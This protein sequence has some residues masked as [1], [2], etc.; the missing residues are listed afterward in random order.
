MTDHA[1][2]AY[3]EVNYPGHPRPS[4]HPD[5]LATIASL[6]GMRPP[7]VP[8]CRVL[9]LG[10]GA[11]QNLVPMAYGLPGSEFLGVDLSR[12]HIDRGTR[13]VDD[14]GLKNVRLLHRN[15]MDVTVELG[16]FDYIIVH[17]VYS[18]VPSDV[19]AK[20]LSILRHQLS[21]NGVAFI[22]YNAYPGSHFRNLARDLMSFHTYRVVDPKE[23]SEQSRKVL[24]VLAELM[25]RDDVYGAVIRDQ[26]D[27][28]RKTPDAVLYH[29]DLAPDAVSFLLH[30]VVDDAARY[31]LQY[32]SEASLSQSSLGAIPPA[33]A[34]FLSQIP[35]NEVVAR[36]QYFDFLASRAFHE[37]LFCRSDVRLRR[38]VGPRCIQNYYLVGRF[39]PVSG[40][41]DPVGCE[42]AAFKSGRGGTLSTDHRLTQV[43]L[44]TLEDCW[45]SAVSFPDLLERTLLR[46]GAQAEGIKA[47]LDE[48]V[49]ALMTTLFRAYCAD[50]IEL[51]LYPPKLATT[52][53][54]RPQASALARMQAKTETLI[55]SLRHGSVL[56]NDD[57]TRRF[58]PIIDGSRSIDELVC[59]LNEV[60]GLSLERSAGN[61]DGV[62]S[63]IRTGVTREHVE[64]N[65]EILARLALLVA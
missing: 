48:E 46:L 51:H 37:T 7:P 31:G 4:T 22:S 64:H 3:D 26:L 27:R 49:E 45:P 9:E 20:V 16:E 12:R 43:A 38:D 1:L 61:A 11:G 34:D 40:E 8:A 55:T 29:D 44:L 30:Q 62:A 56:L 23:K 18:W 13:L 21:A 25:P 33:V 57:V 24:A 19:R 53:S 2:T 65:L 15:I 10:C 50:Q 14:L 28:V 41:I 63:G 5:R 58:L 17:G 52:V 47:R 32:L 42:T 54:L 39:A 59:D 60:L 36:E 35:A 6:F